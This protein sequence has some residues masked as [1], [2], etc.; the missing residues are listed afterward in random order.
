MR[1][2]QLKRHQQATITSIIQLGQA[3]PELVADHKISDA[4]ARRLITL[5]FV[6]GEKVRVLA[7]GLFGGDPILV[8]IGFTRFALRLAEAAR[9]EVSFIEDEQ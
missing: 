2:S 9:I 8:Q 5:G 3:A 4:I 6:P 7:R 1:L